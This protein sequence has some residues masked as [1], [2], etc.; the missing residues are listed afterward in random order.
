MPYFQYLFTVF[1]CKV[2]YI[3]YDFLDYLIFSFVT[4]KK[5]FCEVKY[6]K[7]FRENILLPVFGGFARFGMF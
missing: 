5:L 4:D 1:S 7:I 6:R 3:I 2:M